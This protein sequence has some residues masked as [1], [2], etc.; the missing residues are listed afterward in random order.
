MSVLDVPGL[1]EFNGC[2]DTD[3]DGITDAKDDCP[4][5][6]GTAEF[7]GCADTDGDGIPDPKDECPTVAGLATLKRMS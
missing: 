6:A 7:N 1:A 4:D 2:P 5:V 3:G